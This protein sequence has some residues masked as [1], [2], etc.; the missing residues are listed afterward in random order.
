LSFHKR[1]HQ[2]KKA[3][4]KWVDSKHLRYGA[5]LL[6]SPFSLCFSFDDFAVGP[7]DRYFSVPTK[8]TKRKSNQLKRWSEG[9]RNWKAPSR[10]SFR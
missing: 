10:G 6:I 8:E 3:R 2:L 9:R 4:T 7:K 5:L 1:F